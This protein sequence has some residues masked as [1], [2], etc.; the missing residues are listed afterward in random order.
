MG[1]GETDERLEEQKVDVCFAQL[2]GER[3]RAIEQEDVDKELFCDWM[4]WYD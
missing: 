3:G 2:S 1:D 4:A